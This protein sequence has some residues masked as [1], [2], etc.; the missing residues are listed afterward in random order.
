MSRD[1]ACS[2]VTEAHAPAIQGTGSR[3]PRRDDPLDRR[4]ESNAHADL[5]RRA[6]LLAVLSAPWAVS[7][8]T[9][10]RSGIEGKIVDESGGVMPGVTVT[11][12]SPALQGG[13]ARP[14]TDAEG[15]YRFA[16]L[17]AGTYQVTFELAGFATIK[18]DVAPRHR[19]RRDPERDDDGRGRPGIGHGDHGV[20][21]RRHPH[22]R[23][24]HEPRARRRSRACRPPG[25][26]GR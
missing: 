6:A 20:A 26:C 1:V 12:A 22:D 3:T 8:Q 7:A 18:R 24:Q 11:I 19:L 14:V 9:T 25:A 23:G 16:A 4:R 21:R 5:D 2:A 10:D 15:R 17:P 13:R